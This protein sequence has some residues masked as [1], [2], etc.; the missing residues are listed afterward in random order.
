MKTFIITTVLDVADSCEDR[1]ADISMIRRYI[2]EL[3]RSRVIKKD[4]YREKVILKIESVKS[5]VFEI[6]K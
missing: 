1:K 2:G 3:S 5:E 6:F 4:C